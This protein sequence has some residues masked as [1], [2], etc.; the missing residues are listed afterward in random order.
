MTGTIYAKDGW[1]TNAAMIAQAVKPL[2]YLNGRVIDMTYGLGRF[3]SEW[4]P[5]GLVTVD[6]NPAAGA[7]LVADFRQLPFPDRSFDVAVF[8]GPYKLN[9]RPSQGGPA[10]SDDDY[11]VGGDTVTRWQDRYQL[12]LDGITEACRIADRVLVKCQDQVNSGHVRWQTVDFTVHAARCGFDR[13]DS[14]DFPG[15]RPQP[16]DRS[17]KCP[18]CDTRPG[19]PDPSCTW[20]DGSNRIPTVQHHAARNYST[21]LVFDRLPG[22]RRH[23][24]D[25]FPELRLANPPIDYADGLLALTAAAD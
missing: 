24:T 1:A 25:Q 4:R 7:D 19:G 14:F 9:G 23:Y 3:W 6:L 5:D 18:K 13:V 16:S 8:D 15:Y 17:R 11:G 2:G 20:C 22:R 12:L 21:L 10:T